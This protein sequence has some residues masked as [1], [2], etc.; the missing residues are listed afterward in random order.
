MG[1]T[2]LDEGILQSS[3]IGEDSDV[4]KIWIA[5]LA[6]C[7]EDGVARVSP[8]FLSSVCKLD[9]KA[10]IEALEKLKSPDPYSRSKEEEGRRIKEVDGGYFLVTYQKY[11]ERTYSGTK[12]AIRKREQ[13]T[14]EKGEREEEY[15]DAFISFWSAY[16]NKTGKGAA[17]KSWQKEKPDINIVLEALKWQT[18][19][20]QWTKDKGQFI[21]YPTTYLNQRRWEDE[22][23]I[24]NQFNKGGNAFGTYGLN[25]L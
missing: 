14:R 23:P 12:E 21:P 2:K 10:T 24:Q 18:K 5:L 15:S 16:P 7:K 20:E 22:K 19:Q 11:R 17:Y 13:R 8:V 4:F 1:F 6:A 9:I 3:I 25:N